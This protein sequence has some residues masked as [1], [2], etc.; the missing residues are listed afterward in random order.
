MKTSSNIFLIII[1]LL[2]SSILKAQTP[3]R[4]DI[5]I[6]RNSD[7]SGMT[8]QTARDAI[9][10][11]NNFYSGTNMIFIIDTII[12][13]NTSNT[14]LSFDYINPAL[15]SINN[16]QDPKI[17]NALNIYFFPNLNGG[18]KGVAFNVPG[19]ACAVSYDFA[20][21]STIAHEVGHCFGLFHT[22]EAYYGLENVVR[23]YDPATNCYPNWDV[24]GDKIGDTPAQQNPSY[25]STDNC[26]NSYPTSQLSS[27]TH[28]ISAKSLSPFFTLPTPLGVPVNIKS[29]FSNV[30]KDERYSTITAGV[31]IILFNFSSCLFSPLTER[32]IFSSRVKL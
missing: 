26:G 24:A 7:G 28:E 25:S 21:S 3:I 10:T 2:L 20:L 29:P 30:I 12:T 14:T 1:L 22:D 18:A 5:H 8:E 27:A 32:E 17:P 16:L 31:N 11:L 6:I 9:D 13:V 15:V 19:N 23:T 4:T